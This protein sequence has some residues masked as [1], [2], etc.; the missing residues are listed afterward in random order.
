MQTSVWSILHY[1]L[2]DLVTAL[3]SS[4]LVSGIWSFGRFF[5][6][7]TAASIIFLPSGTMPWFV[8]HRS[9][10]ACFAIALIGS[11]TSTTSWLSRSKVP[12]TGPVMRETDVLVCKLNRQVIVHVHVHLDV[13]LLTWRPWCCH[14][15]RFKWLQFAF[16]PLLC[17]LYSFNFII[18][19][20]FLELVICKKITF[21]VIAWPVE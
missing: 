3:F 1:M 20:F 9:A 2:P 15:L 17:C 21:D 12:A 11:V 4:L 16:P 14:W 19:Y 13:D 10:R 18:I 6:T 7:S 8:L 5:T